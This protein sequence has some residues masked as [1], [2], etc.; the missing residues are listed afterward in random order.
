MLVDRLLGGLV[1]FIHL[2]VP[3]PGREY[4]LALG[5]K[6]I[7]QLHGLFQNTAT[8]T[9][10]VEY[11]RGNTLSFQL[12]QGPLYLIGGRIGETAQIDVSHTVTHHAIIRHGRYLYLFTGKFKGKC[13]LDTRT[14]DSHLQLGIGRAFQPLAH[15]STLPTRYRIIV[16]HDNLVAGSQTGQ[17]GRHT[18][19]GFRNID[20]LV[21]LHDQGAYTGI[22][23]GSREEEII[24]LFLGNIFG[25]RVQPGQHRIHPVVDSLLGIDGIDIKQ[26]QLLEQRVE[27]IEV[28][29]DFKIPPVRL[30]GL[31]RAHTAHTKGQCQHDSHAQT[32]FSHRAIFCLGLTKIVNDRGLRQ[33]SRPLLTL[34]QPIS[35]RSS[36]SLSP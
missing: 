8:V 36:W 7:D 2:L 27:Y 22:L 25:V 15:G 11:K 4:L 23:P 35:H 13:T 18:L 20:R 28:S 17:L 1:D 21:T 6:Q 24:F 29:R 16:D 19:I 12:L 14:L 3:P 31:H 5:D 33:S 30:P 32:C 34:F 26:V 10:Q 9:P